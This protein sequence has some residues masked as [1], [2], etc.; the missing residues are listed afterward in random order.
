MM[1]DEYSTFQENTGESDRYRAL[2]TSMKRHAHAES[3]MSYTHIVHLAAHHPTAAN[4][5]ACR[6]GRKRG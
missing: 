5:E 3:A 2:E 6:Q 4:Q 1:E